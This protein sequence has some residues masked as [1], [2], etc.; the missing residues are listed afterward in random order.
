LV[1]CASAA[2]ASVLALAT[3]AIRSYRLGVAIGR[4]TLGSS[5]DWVAPDYAALVYTPCAG[6]SRWPNRTFA[7]VT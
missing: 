1:S 4:R 7:P 3:K 2:C 6:L 5:Q